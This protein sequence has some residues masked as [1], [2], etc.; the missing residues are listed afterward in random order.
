MKAPI[1]SFRIGLA[2][3]AVFSL[4]SCEKKSADSNSIGTAEFSV[5]VPDVIQTKSATSGESVLASFQVMISVEDLSGKPVLTDKMIPVYAFGTGYV[6][7][8]LEMNPG[9][10]RLTKFLV[11]DPSG[12]VVQAAPKTGSPLAYLTTR[13]LPL[14]FNIF[15]NQVTK[16]LP[17]V[18]PV[19]NQTPDKFGYAT[20]GVQV[21]KPL[22]F[23]TGAVIDNPTI[24][25]PTPLFTE[26]NLTISTKD[27]WHYTFKLI[28]SLNNLVIRGGSDIYTFTLEKSGYLPVK[29]DFSAS[30]LL[31]ATKEKPLYLKIPSDAVYKT[32]VLQPGPDLG[33][34]AMVSNL[35]PD[36]NFGDYKYFEAT[37]LTEGVLTVM[38]SNRSMIWFDLSQLPKSAVIKKVV[39]KLSYD[40]PVPYDVTVFP[41]TTPG[42]TLWYGAVLQQIIEPWDEGKVTWNTQPKSTEIN[43]VFVSPFIKNANVIEL[44]VTRLFVNPTASA[45]ANLLPNWGMLFRLFPVE[46]FPGFR[47]ASSDFTVATMRPQ[48]GVSYTI[49]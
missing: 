41:N 30:V 24:M 4:Y 23:W 12:S 46:K 7:E 16:I 14:T 8:N 39:L 47:F 37:F 9:G 20:F 40:V 32:L 44:D 43:Q 49:N 42:T 27:G 21:I 19:E 6:S 17:E 22:S 36:K 18:L 10:F 28:A 45:T 2:M 3:L 11:I 33:K 34:D 1:S 5:N 29:A 35:E 38:R 25:A 48:I 15:P 26:A 31:A 13:P